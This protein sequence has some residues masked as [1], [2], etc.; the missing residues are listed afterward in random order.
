M[1]PQLRNRVKF[2]GPPWLTSDK[3][4]MPDGT[5]KDSDSRL[6]YSVALMFDALRAR[7]HYGMLARTPDF[8]PEDA[9]PYVGKGLDMPRGPSEPLESY[10]ARLKGGI[11]DKRLCGTAWPMMRQIRGY[12]TP[13]AV[14]VRI[15]NE[16]GHFYTIDR[17]GSMSR[18]RYSSWNWDNATVL[19]KLLK[20]TRVRAGG[21]LGPALPWGRFWVIIYPTTGSPTQPWQRDGTWGDGS[22]W[23]EDPGTWGS[24]ATVGDVFAIRRIVRRWKPDG[25]R[26][27]SIIISFDD[28]AFDP[29]SSPL[30][31]GTWKDHA[32]FDPAH[33]GRMVPAR[34]PNAIYWGGTS[35][36]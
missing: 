11:D 32:K 22:V 35:A 16:K 13:H 28:T 6:L 31:D 17:D 24:T 7:L 26:C 5:E 25:S 27:V 29:A 2:L 21:S 4:R 18:Y 14:R 8:A 3:I 30:P 36:A 23:G 1:I 34:N 20:L 15:V 33:P 10:R 19:A 9:L 12:C